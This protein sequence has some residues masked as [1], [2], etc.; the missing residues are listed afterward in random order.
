MKLL[1]LVEMLDLS[2][3]IGV[4]STLGLISVVTTNCLITLYNNSFNEDNNSLALFL[5]GIWILF[6]VLGNMYKAISVDT[7][8]SSIDL[9][10]VLLPEWRYCSFCE[11]NAPPRCF[12][13]FTCNKCVLKR[14][15][16]CM[17]LGKCAGHKNFRYYLAFILYILLAVM[18]SDLI[19][20]DYYL[21]IF[22]Y[23]PSF[24]SIFICIMPL[25]GVILGMI[26]IFDFIYIFTNSVT[27]I[28]LP[29]MFLY[30]LMNYKMA[31]TG[32]TWH[33]N[34]KNIKFYN[35]GLV[36]NAKD[37]FGSNWLMALIFPFSA[38]KLPSDGTRFRKN[39]ISS[40]N[41]QTT[42]ASLNKETHGTF[43]RREMN[44]VHNY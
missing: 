17:F 5:I 2:D 14:H 15:N 44:T 21:N 39:I 7:T 29:L 1:K 28:L 12:H 20:L 24:K 18:M 37:A 33:E 8:I 26:N 10:T 25:F 42:H 4:I 40:N 34:A 19:H 41:T 11:Q 16:H 6:N 35:L 23:N 36:Q 43:R 13:C 22:W 32:Q 38:Q 31:L 9:P 3:K 30:V 27:L